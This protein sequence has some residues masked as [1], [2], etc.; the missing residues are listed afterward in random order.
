M[1][2]SDAMAWLIRDTQV[3]ASLEVADGFWA[4]STGLL[5]RK[6]CDGAMLLTH[7]RGVHSIG[8]RFAMDV[9]FLDADRVV[10]E[11]V[12][13]RPMRVTRPRTKARSIL[14]A[15]AG[16]FERWGL[17]VGDRLDVEP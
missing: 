4:R 15:E 12:R 2:E 11:V 16:A 6:S 7:A 1:R 5:G 17:A 10:L 9:A 13:L 3:L 8:M 14:E